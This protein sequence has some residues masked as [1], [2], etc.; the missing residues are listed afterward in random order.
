MA[1]FPWFHQRPKGVFAVSEV[2]VEPEVE[3]A[4][5]YWWIFVVVGVAWLLFAVIVFRF[6]YRSVNAIS[7]LFGIVMIVA[8]LEELLTV[9]FA[10]KTGWARFA[11]V[12][13]ALA[14]A[15]IGVVAFVH[16][17]NTFDALAAVLSFYFILKG[18]FNVGLAVGYRHVND[19]WWIQ[20]LIGIVEIV[21][22][23]WAAGDFGHRQ[24]LLIVWVGVVA[25]T[26]G[27]AAIIVGFAARD[28]RGSESPAGA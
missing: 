17:G 6:D 16:P 8:A 9:F 14:F 26:R 4:A 23:F 19:F 7:I 15:V 2:E 10:G 12:V 21:I 25:L 24:I 11:H 18:A 27:V 3:A 22:G 1:R 20:L 5:R 13:F 28:L